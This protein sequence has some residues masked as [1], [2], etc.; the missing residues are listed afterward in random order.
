M[1][2]EQVGKLYSVYFV[3][4]CTPN[5][6]RRKQVQLADENLR[7]ATLRDVMDN[8]IVKAGAMP[9]QSSLTRMMKTH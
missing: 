1:G 9:R 7:V 6:R 2:F 5:L 8:D 3:H 4:Y